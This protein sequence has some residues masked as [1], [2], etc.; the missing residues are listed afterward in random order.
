MARSHGHETVIGSV[1]P[2]V[3]LLIKSTMGAVMQ[4]DNGFYAELVDRGGNR[5]TEVL[6]DPAMPVHAVHAPGKPASVSQDT[7]TGSTRSRR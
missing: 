5:A 2:T 7:V 3:Y 6:I 4:F 1:P